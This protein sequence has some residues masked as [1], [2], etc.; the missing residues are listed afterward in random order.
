MKIK[1]RNASQSLRLG[2]WSGPRSHCEGGSCEGRRTWP[3]S[4]SPN[5]APAT[6]SA[7]E[8]AAFPHPLQR[9]LWKGSFEA[10]RYGHPSF[11]PEAEPRGAP[12]AAEEPWGRGTPRLARGRLLG[13]PTVGFTAAA[14]QTCWRLREVGWVQLDPHTRPEGAHEAAW[15]CLGGAGISWGICP[16][17]LLTAV[18]SRSRLGPSDC[19]CLLTTSPKH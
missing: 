14:P 7:A 6:V 3:R 19:S 9:A 1:G 15:C 8:R 16:G 5:A 10:P 13:V 17:S 11:L 2:T 4:Q 18:V 12:E